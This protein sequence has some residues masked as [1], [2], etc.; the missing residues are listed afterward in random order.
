MVQTDAGVE[1]RVRDNVTKE[2]VQAVSFD[3]LS[4]GL[5]G[6]WY[7]AD[8]HK[9]LITFI[10]GSN[11]SVTQDIDEIGEPLCSDGMESG[12]YT[13]DS[14][15]GNFSLMNMIDTNGDCGLTSMQGDTYDSTVTVGGNILTV[16]DVEGSIHLAR[17][18]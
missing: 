2:P 7:F 14:G 6:S 17:V 18:Q 12:T 5:I 13:W 16:I 15:S 8:E 9:T 11:Y 10:D 3:E 1:L 4:T